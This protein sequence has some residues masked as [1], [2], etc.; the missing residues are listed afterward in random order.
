MACISPAR[1]DAHEPVFSGPQVGEGLPT[2]RV[3]GVF[4]SDAGKEIDFVAK[5]KGAPIVLI[6]VH[7]LNRP[8]IA[9]T[10]ILS[11]YTHGRAKDGL[12]T[13]VVWL[14]DDI[15]NAENDLQRIRHALTIEAP[16]GISVDGREGPGSYGLNRQVTLTI[17]VGNRGKV[18][19]N[20]AL[21]QPSLQAD[22]PKILE[23]VVAV[24]GGTVPKLEDLEGMKGMEAARSM[25]SSAPDMRALLG[26]LIRKTASEQEVD[27]AAE[28]IE[29][30]IKK[31]E[32]VKK[33]IGRISSTIVNAGKLKDYGTPKAQEYLAKWAKQ[34]GASPDLK[35]R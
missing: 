34:Y 14:D 22:L 9:M 20:H 15:S 24:V 16:T 18:T 29:A 23:S 2:F 10:R 17:L 12:H 26:P 6:F 31:D 28:T 8:S 7:D 25:P 21:V 13:G 27:T 33:E 32:A 19:A 1:M 4:G 3:R 35:N 11:L 30:Q 5:A